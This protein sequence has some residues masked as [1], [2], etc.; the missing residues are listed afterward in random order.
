M[1]VIL[2]SKISKTNK[3][4]NTIIASN[5]SIPESEY[6][7]TGGESTIPINI[8]GYDNTKDNLTVLYYGY[9]TELILGD[10]YSISTDSLNIVLIGWNLILGSIVKFK[11]I[12][13]PI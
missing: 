6:I 8:S 12:K 10:N 1:D 5:V 13:N 7:A 2:L 11:V 9:G 4:L 3:R